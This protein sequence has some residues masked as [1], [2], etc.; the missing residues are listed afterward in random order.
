MMRYGKSVATALAAVMMVLS[1]AGCGNNGQQAEKPQLVRTQTVS[2]SNGSAVG[3]YSGT[4]RGRYETALAF[5]TGGRILQ[6]NVNVGDRVS[7][8]DVLMVIDA[9]DA[10][11][12]A[13]QG[14]AAVSSA[15]AQL[16]LAA[17]NLRRYQELYNEE[18]VSAAVLDQYQTSYD[19]AQAAYENAVAQS[20]EGHNVLGY[21]NLTA[22]ASGVISAVNVEAGQVVAAGTPALQLVQTEELEVEIEVP[23]GDTESIQPGMRAEV[24]FWS[25]NGVSVEG[26]VREVAPM[27]DKVSRTYRVRVSVPE[28]P[29]GISLGMTASVSLTKPASGRELAELPLTAIYQTGDT[30]EVW[31]V[32]ED[33]TVSLKNVSVEEYG[34]NTVRVDGLSDGD[35]VVTA[36]VHK[37]HE[38]QNVRVGDSEAGL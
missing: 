26:T 27:A 12:K 4:V 19:A 28:L 23:E 35:I 20:V 11:Q 2:L 14:D 22:N 3:K 18:A 1:A 17:A 8:G 29:Q 6:R 24:T 31:V 7:A 5:Q 10:V 9:R 37:L 16:T 15:R 13:N 38:G 36:G 34:D 30:P 21:T 25:N 33:G 32:G